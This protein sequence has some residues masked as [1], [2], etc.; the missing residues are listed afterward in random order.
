MNKLYKVTATAK[1]P[2]QRKARNR[3]FIVCADSPAAAVRMVKETQNVD[4]HKFSFTEVEGG[5]YYA[6]TFAY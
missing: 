2:G 5:V 1:E 4:G 6:G 3:D